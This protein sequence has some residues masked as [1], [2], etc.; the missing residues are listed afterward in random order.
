MF[1]NAKAIR[2]IKKTVIVE[3]LSMES[4]DQSQMSSFR[5]KRHEVGFCSVNCLEFYLMPDTIAEIE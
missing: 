3:K 5:F 4:R 1:C 2:N